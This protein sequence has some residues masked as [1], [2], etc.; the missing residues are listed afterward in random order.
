MVEFIPTYF[1]NKTKKIILPLDILCK[2][3]MLQTPYHAF[4]VS[5]GLNDEGVSNVVEDKNSTMSFVKLV[6]I[7]GSG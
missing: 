5:P 1:I 4:P 3:A 6:G 7:E 2:R